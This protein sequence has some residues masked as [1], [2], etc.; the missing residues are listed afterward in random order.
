MSECLRPKRALSKARS[1]SGRRGAGSRESRQRLGS[2]AVTIVRTGKV[3]PIRRP[4][5]VVGRA[6]SAQ[7]C[8]CD[9]WGRRQPVM[10]RKLIRSGLVFMAVVVMGGVTGCSCH[11]STC[12]DGDCGLVYDNDYWEAGCGAPSGHAAGCGGCGAPVAHSGC[13]HPQG[14]SA[15]CGG[16]GVPH[17]QA[18]NCSTCGGVHPQPAPVTDQPGCA[19]CGEHHGPAVEGAPPAEP[20]PPESSTASPPPPPLPPSIPEIPQK[21]APPARKAPV[22]KK[23]SVKA[24]P[25]AGQVPPPLQTVPAGNSAEPAPPLQPV[26]VPLPALEKPAPIPRD[27]SVQPQWIPHRL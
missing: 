18:P 19:H 16:C 17:H 3:R 7:S 12:Y 13:S 26:E 23:R 25:T 15:G 2:Q 6:G 14:H 10:V 22:P 9:N 4:M 11:R 27:A 8:P 5:S 1:C 24:K 21:S 20:A